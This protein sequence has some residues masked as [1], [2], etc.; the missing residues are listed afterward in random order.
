L[1]ASTLGGINNFTRRLV[2]DAVVVSL[3]ANPNFFVSYHVSLSNPSQLFRKERT[4]GE[5]QAALIKLSS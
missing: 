1:C 3:Q 2:E 5:L 4:G